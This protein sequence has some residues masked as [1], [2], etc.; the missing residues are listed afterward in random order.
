VNLLTTT[1][2]AIFGTAAA[3]PIISAGHHGQP[4]QETVAAAGFMSLAVAIIAASL[5]VLWG[6][7]PSALR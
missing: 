6:L 4:W 7:R 1:F 3:N 5:L 2:A